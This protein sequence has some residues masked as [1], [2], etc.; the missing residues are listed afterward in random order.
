MK[1]TSIHKEIFSSPALWWGTGAIIVLDV[2]SQGIA[3]DW[4]SIDYRPTALAGTSTFTGIVAGQYIQAGLTTPAAKNVIQSISGPLHCSSGFLTSALSVNA[5]TLL[6]MGLYNYGLFFA[7]MQDLK[8]ANRQMIIGSAAVGAGFLFT[9]G[10]MAALATWGTASTGTAIATLSGAA[11]TNASLALL[12]GGTIAMGGG[13]VVLGTAVLTGGTIV[14]AI[15][16]TYLGYKL[17]E[18][19][20]ASDEKARINAMVNFFSNEENLR[21]AI[22]QTPHGRSLKQ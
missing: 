4:Q 2:I 19:K 15:A 9:T 14:V 7:G 12:G 3:K 21:K 20:D 6:A 16:V 8:I 5:A 17:Y 10:T 18:L 1:P 22:L 11:A 13:G